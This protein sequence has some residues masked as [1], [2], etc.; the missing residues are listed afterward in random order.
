[1]AHGKLTT[2]PDA[3]SGTILFHNVDTPSRAY[4]HLTDAVLRAAFHEEW[5]QVD[6]ESIPPHTVIGQATYDEEKEEVTA[7]ELNDGI[8]REY[9]HLA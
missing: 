2:G 9:G 6:V 7:L 5:V 3:E 4:E 8:L 1:M